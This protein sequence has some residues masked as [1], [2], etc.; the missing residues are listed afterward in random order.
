VNFMHVVEQ[1]TSAVLQR[2]G[3]THVIH[4]RPIDE[5]TELVAAIEPLA[6]YGPYT[7]ARF[8]PE[9]APFATLGGE[10]GGVEIVQR[11]ATRVVL[12]V[13]P[14][15]PTELT[16]AWAP[17]ERWAWTV[18]GEPRE[19]AHAS[20]RGGVELLAVDVDRPARV[21]LDYVR[22]PRERYATWVTWIAGVIVIGGLAFAR[23]LAFAPRL[24]T[25]RSRWALRGALAVLAGT[26]LLAGR[27]R[28]HEQLAQTWDE[29]ATTVTTDPESDPMPPFLGDLTAERAI[30]I[31]RT[32]ERICVGLLGK[33]PLAGCQE[34]EGGPFVS[35]V[36]IEP[37]LYRCTHFTIAPGGEAE[38]VLGDPGDELMLV[39]VRRGDHR[40]RHLR[41]DLESAGRSLGSRALVAR[42][43]L[44]VRP[45]PTGE[46]ARVQIVNGG[47]DPER[48]CLA[49]AR[50]GS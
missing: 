5:E 1:R 20:V 49:A 14:S 12:D 44:R 4:D 7:L 40:G 28:Q 29:Y 39:L 9:P 2:L 17:S 43:E 45:S 13:S 25:P 19:P 35:M 42:A 38:A 27:H 24:A 50:F 31:T 15:E 34:S 22:H 23:P 46:P 21:V 10:E 36:Y 33:D 8:L 16:L 26:V 3:V 47:D 32:P 41:Y 37:Y 48:I 11:S 6:T 18:D 30:E